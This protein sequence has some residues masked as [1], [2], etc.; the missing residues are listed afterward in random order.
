MVIY[1]HRQSRES[2]DDG[3]AP[4]PPPAIAKRGGELHLPPP[5]PPLTQSPRSP[6]DFEIS[7]NNSNSKRSPLAGSKSLPAVSEEGCVSNCDDEFINAKD[8]VDEQQDQDDDDDLDDDDDDDD[9]DDVMERGFETPVPVPV[10]SSTTTPQQ[11]QSTAQDSKKKR[12]KKITFSKK[13]RIKEIRHLNDYSQEEL[14]AFFMTMEDY[15]LAKGV[16]KTTVRMMMTNPDLIQKDDPEFC[17]RGLEFRTRTGS[18]TRSKNKM[19][20]RVAVLNEQDIQEEEGFRDPELLQFASMSESKSVR[21]EARQRGVEDEQCI[22]DYCWDVRQI[23]WSP[24]IATRP[25]FAELQEDEGAEQP[26]SS[27]SST[28]TTVEQQKQQ[29]QQ[30]PKQVKSILTHKRCMYSQSR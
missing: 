5:S 16:V 12:K 28:T 30:Q 17:P 21:E 20:C 14:D 9:D 24:K 22:Q 19:R 25:R 18:Q 4:P 15:Q 8:F 26:R 6:I 13:L 7:I 3:I 23:S 27:S 11:Q 2:A 1:Q 29:M 10:T